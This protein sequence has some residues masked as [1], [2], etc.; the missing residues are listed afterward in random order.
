MAAPVQLG[1]KQ[2]AMDNAEALAVLGVEINI[3]SAIPYGRTDILDD[4]M[5]HLLARLEE[6]RVIGF[7]SA[8]GSTCTRRGFEISP[9]QFC[10]YLTD[11][12]SPVLRA[13]VDH[14]AIAPSQYLCYR[15]ALRAGRSMTI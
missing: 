15:H 5:L 13:P 11:T 6:P 8:S 10:R 3:T 2:V 9:Y 4:L 14:V 1:V 12:S 7:G